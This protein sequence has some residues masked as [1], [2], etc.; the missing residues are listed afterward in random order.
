MPF[1]R[2]NGTP[3]KASSIPNHTWNADLVEFEGP[4]ISLYRSERGD[5]VIYVWLDCTSTRNR[6][7]IV[8]L[9]RDSLQD[10]LQCRIPLRSVFERSREIIVFDV[11]AGLKRTGFQ[12][13]TWSVFPEQYKPNSESFLSSAIA[14]VSAQRLANDITDDYFLGLDGDDL[15]VEDLSAIQKGFVQLYSFHYG[16]QYLDRHAVRHKVASHVGQWTGGMSSVWI[17]D[18]LSSVIPSIHR[19]RIGELRF[20]S[21][22]HIKLN[23]LPGLASDVESSVQRILDPV[24]F[25]DMEDFYKRVYA[26]FKSSGISGFESERRDISRY[27]TSEVKATLSGFVSTYLELMG[28]TSQSR[29]LDELEESPLAQLRLLFAYYRRLR[30]LRGYVIE[31]RLVVGAS[32]L[33][34]P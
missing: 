2:V 25:S 16:L 10:Y 27:L 31:G 13:T 7:A 28:W 15:Y 33:A 18:G 29:M 1:V 20:N 21:P 12:A 3:I 26:Y 23:L 17:F 11:G 8:P 34:Q 9:S 32:R 4:L 30:K 5:D 22:G 24:V 19:P 6:W 14:T